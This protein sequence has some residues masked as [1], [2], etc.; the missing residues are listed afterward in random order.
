MPIEKFSELLGRLKGTEN[1]SDAQL[2]RPAFPVSSGVALVMLSLGAGRLKVSGRS[3]G[4]Y[5]EM[6]EG[7]PVAPPLS[8]SELK[9][10]ITRATSIEELRRLR[11][12]FARCSHPDCHQASDEPAAASEMAAANRLIDEALSCLRRRVEEEHLPTSKRAW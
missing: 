7:T 4:Y 5:E 8:L 12:K 6:L 2:N 10:Q 9:L 11:R 3:R 1:D